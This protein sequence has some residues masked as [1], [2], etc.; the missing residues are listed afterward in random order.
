MFFLIILPSI[1]YSVEY[2][3][4]V[5]KKI[6]SEHEYTAKEISKGQFSVLIKENN[7]TS[8]LSRCSFVRSKNKV[9]CDR[10]EVNKISADKNLKIKKYYVFDSHFDVQLFSNLTFIEN[11]GR[12]GIGFGKCQVV[13]P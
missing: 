9:T 4:S 11:N 5:I 8:Y 1:V 12:G 6:N 13:A 10:Y 3:C 7:D 2:K